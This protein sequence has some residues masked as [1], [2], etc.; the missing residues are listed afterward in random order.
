LS[1]KIRN[2]QRLRHDQ[3]AEQGSL[4]KRS[5]VQ[6]NPNHFTLQLSGT[7]HHVADLDTLC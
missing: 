3:V 4:D 6:G 5:A 7:Q 2:L 1:H